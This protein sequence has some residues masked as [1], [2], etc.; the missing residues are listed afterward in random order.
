MSHLRLL[1]T[2]KEDKSYDLNLHITNKSLSSGQMQKIAFVRA[3]MSDIDILLL[4]ESTSNLDENSTEK[5]FQLLSNKKITIIN[6]T[7]DPDKFTNSDGR[8]EIKISDETRRL[9]YKP[10]Q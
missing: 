5:I 3:L 2:F 1:D 9:D 6:S 10:N 7:H 4:D 8:I